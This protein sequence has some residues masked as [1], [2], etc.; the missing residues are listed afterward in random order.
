[1]SWYAVEAIE[2]AIEGTR[3]LLL[4]FD[5][6]MWLRLAVI[7][8]FLGGTSTVSPIQGGT[9]VSSQSG[10]SFPVTPGN[11]SLPSGSLATALLVFFVVI[12]L[13]ALLFTLIGSVME[14]AF[15]ESLRTQRVHVRRYAKSYLGNGLSLFA[16]RLV[17][18]LIVLLPVAGIVL[19]TVPSLS[20]GSANVAVGTLLFLLSILFV[21]GLFVALIDALTKAFV[22]PVMLVRDVGVFAGWEA[23]WPTLKREWKQYGVYLILRFFIAIAASFVVSIVGGILSI[24]L[25]IPFVIIAVLLVVAFGGFGAVGAMLSNPA[26]VAVFVVLLVVYIVCAIFVLA[27]VRVPVQAYTGYFSLLVLGDSNEAFDLIPDLRERIR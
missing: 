19:V 9:R 26:T 16:F 6:S 5:A 4:P 25:L 3:E 14:F 20:G 22:V 10:S 23:F 18:F 21:L 15:I 13:L 8:F 1:M 2:D 17:L 7:V 24:I 12:V 27:L 11:V